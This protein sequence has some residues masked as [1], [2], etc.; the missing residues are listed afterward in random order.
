[1]LFFY[2]G[3]VEIALN[4]IKKAENAE[5][6]PIVEEATYQCYNR[7]ENR[8]ILPRILFSTEL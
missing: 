3:I 7:E 6:H 1:M 2:S 5:N 4:C 8:V